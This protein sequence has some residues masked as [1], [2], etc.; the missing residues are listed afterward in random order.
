MAYPSGL[1]TPL[2]KLF[3]GGVRI[4][5]KYFGKVGVN[6]GDCSAYYLLYTFK[7]FLMDMFPFECFSGFI[8]VIVVPHSPTKF[9]S[10]LRI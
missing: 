10:G 2:P 8:F 7:G 4:D 3:A 6:V 9:I 5:F 1:S